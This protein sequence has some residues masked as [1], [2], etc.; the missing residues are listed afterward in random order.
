MDAEQIRR[1]VASNPFVTMGMSF[2]N[3]KLCWNGTPKSKN[4]LTAA[5][6]AQVPWA[7]S[8]LW[9]SEDL[10]EIELEVSG[11]MYK[12]DDKEFDDKLKVFFTTLLYFF[13]LVHAVMHVYAYIMLGAANQATV[14]TKL[15]SFMG[16][17]EKKIFTKYEEV[18]LLLLKKGGLVCGG[19][20]KVKN[21]TAAYNLGNIVFQY[22]A[23]QQK[24]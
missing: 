12:P 19:Y 23:K 21:D 3:K 2:E 7:V 17:Y 9:L 13:E 11:K 22:L 10:K 8:K 5:I 16:Q 18:A 24:C 15:Q 6:M 4:Q 20:W 1:L 14:G